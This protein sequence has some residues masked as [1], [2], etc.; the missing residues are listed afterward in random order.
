MQT[1]LQ[2]QRG[3]LLIILPLSVVLLIGTLIMYQQLSIS[4][5]SIS[6]VLNKSDIEAVSHTINKNVINNLKQKSCLDLDSFLNIQNQSTT[7]ISVSSPSELSSCLAPIDEVAKLDK[8][9]VSITKLYGGQDESLGVSTIK[10]NQNLQ[11]IQSNQALL[12]KNDTTSFIHLKIFSLSDLALVMT[13]GQSNSL[14]ISDNSKLKVNGWTYIHGSQPP[15]LSS[16]AKPTFFSTPGSYY[17]NDPVLIKAPSWDWTSNAEGFSLETMQAVFHGGLFTNEMRDVNIFPTDEAPNAWEQPT[18]YYYVYNKS[19]GYPLPSSMPAA[20]ADGYDI[21]DP[22]RAQIT[23]FPNPNVISNMLLT[24][25]STTSM[26]RGDAKPMILY[27]AKS[28]VSLDLKNSPGFC[29]MIIAD[30]LTINT[31]P[32]VKTLLIGTFIANRLVIRGGGQV[33]IFN[34]LHSSQTPTE[35]LAALN[36]NVDLVTR[37]LLVLRASIAYN[38]FL[39]IFKTKSG[40]TGFSPTDLAQ[41]FE[42]CGANMCW[43]TAIDAFNWNSLYSQADWYKKVL[44]L[45][46]EGL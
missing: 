17:F 46:E 15:D 21:V 8:S 38:F 25:G 41:F 44:F 45:M 26:N 11:N 1:Q 16:W 30:T 22:T 13:S 24:C 3:Q 35:E 18:D 5:S 37:Q 14:T 7:S 23:N 20:H 28:N 40:I 2:N 31:A 43:K 12:L 6:Y 39:P 10:I 4:A 36:I 32:D 29:G 34:P 27:R 9:N 33:I 19:L 42:P